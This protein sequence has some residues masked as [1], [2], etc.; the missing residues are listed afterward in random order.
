MGESEWLFVGRKGRQITPADVYQTV[1]K[2]M[3]A[4]SDADRVSP[5]VFRHS[6]ATQILNEGGSI[7]AIRELLGHAD[8][9]TTEVYT[10][11]TREHLKEVYKH[12][13]PRR[14]KNEH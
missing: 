9:A 7:E 6:F 14:I 5:H 4:L 1:R 2:Y 10:H 11:V 12:A 3:T 13:H 8:L